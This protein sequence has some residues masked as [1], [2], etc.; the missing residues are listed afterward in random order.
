MS[1]AARRAA[2]LGALGIDQWTLRRPVA[3]APEWGTL[4]AAVRGCSR[5]ALHQ[6]RTQAVFGVGDRRA[7]WMVVG[8]A[9][10]AEEDRQGEPFVGAAGQL[11]MAMLAAIGL[12]RESVFI[13]DAL[14]CRPPEDHAPQAGEIA[15]C[16]SHLQQQVE[17]LRPTIILAFGRIAAQ[18]LLGREA[19]LDELRGRVHRFGGLNTPVVVTYHPA[20]LL[21]SPGDKRKAWED[22]KLA[23]QAHAGL[24]TAPG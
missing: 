8:D 6:G 20:H 23:R 10:G 3:P 1:D 7:G 21:H 16:R 17:L 5:C 14:K 22:L 4:E 15:A 12:S 11:L 9:P 19:A 24:A 2:Y 18:S 13:T